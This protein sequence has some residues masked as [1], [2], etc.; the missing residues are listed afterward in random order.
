M[1]ISASLYGHKLGAVFLNILAGLAMLMAALGLY[2]V[3]AY[4]VAQR[5]GE[6]GI[7]MA[8]GATPRDI[9]ALVLR[10][11]LGFALGGL[12]AGSLA[13]VA[14]AR[15]VASFLVQVSPADPAVYGCVALFTVT[16]ALLSAAI[17]A[18]RALR[19]DPVEA[20]RCQ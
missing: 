20:L 17:P 4:S 6:L 1:D 3:M 18:W 7:R 9:L 11:G 19:V 10:Q 14:L 2:G 8:V 13:A 12:A 16:V 15:V 5:A